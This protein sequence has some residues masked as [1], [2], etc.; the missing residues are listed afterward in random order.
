MKQT[1]KILGLLITLPFDVIIGIIKGIITLVEYFQNK[2]KQERM[3]ENFKR[4]N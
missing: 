2:G 1:L 3:K 4:N